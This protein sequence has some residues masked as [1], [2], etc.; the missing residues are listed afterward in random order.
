MS[1]MLVGMVWLRNRNVALGTLMQR[2]SSSSVFL[3]PARDT[4]KPPSSDPTMKAPV[5]NVP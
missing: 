4:I 2:Q 5:P 1:D 3:R